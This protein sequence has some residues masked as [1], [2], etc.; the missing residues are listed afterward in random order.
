MMVF[1]ERGGQVRAVTLVVHGVEYLAQ[2]TG[3]PI[4]D[5]TLPVRA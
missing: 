3:F 4:A 1:V 2:V 5:A